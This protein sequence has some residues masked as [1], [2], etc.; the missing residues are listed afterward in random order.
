VCGQMNGSLL[1]QAAN[2]MGSVQASANDVEGIL[3]Y[4][5]G[6]DFRH[7]QEMVQCW[8]EF[9]IK[10]FDSCSTFYMNLPFWS[11]CSDA[12][13]GIVLQVWALSVAWRGNTK[14]GY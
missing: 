9:L 6:Y 3:Q 11:I 1:V 2:I 10:L 14:Q 8:S 4:G 5:T 13:L 12:V 7:L